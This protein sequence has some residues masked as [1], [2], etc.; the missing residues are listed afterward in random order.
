MGGRGGVEQKEGEVAR[1][2]KGELF[3]EALQEWLNE[4]D[5]EWSDLNCST[6][7]SE[8]MQERGCNGQ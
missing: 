4:L 5:L 7:A 2:G 1:E 3:W 6:Q 8:G